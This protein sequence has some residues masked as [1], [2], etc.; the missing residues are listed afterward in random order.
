MTVDAA[1]REHRRQR[2]YQVLV[3]TRS[4]PRPLSRNTYSVLRR[5]HVRRVR[6]PPASTW[7]PGHGIEEASPRGA[8]RSPA[9]FSAAV[10]RGEAERALVH[11]GRDDVVRVGRE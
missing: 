10:E 4:R 3:D 11:V 2:A 9:P 8:R 7:L 6:D 1:L 5:D